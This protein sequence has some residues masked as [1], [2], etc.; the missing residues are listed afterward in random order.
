MEKPRPP[1][2]DVP[3]NLSGLS[4]SGLS[5]SGPSISGPDGTLLVVEE[6]EEQ[7]RSKE[8]SADQSRENVR[9]SLSQSPGEKKKKKRPGRQKQGAIMSIKAPTPTPPR[10]RGRRI[11]KTLHHCL[12]LIAVK[13]SFL[14]RRACICIRH[15]L[16]PYISP[17]SLA[18]RL[19]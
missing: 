3:S 16:S 6:E 1:R 10:H 12:G 19:I 14:S 13:A 8:Q 18:T 11:R 7:D 2:F 9:D 15:P 5:I 4:I 17:R